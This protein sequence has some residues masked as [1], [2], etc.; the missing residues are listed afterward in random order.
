LRRVLFP[1]GFCRS[2]IELLSFEAN[3]FGAVEGASLG[4]V[5]DLN[6]ED[7]LRLHNPP[8]RHCRYAEHA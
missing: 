2:S 7:L 6:I 8:S 1:S 4:C 3:R 5:V